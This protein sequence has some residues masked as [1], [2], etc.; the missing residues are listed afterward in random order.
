MGQFPDAPHLLGPGLTVLVST[1]ARAAQE[2]CSVGCAWGQILGSERSRELPEPPRSGD[3]ATATPGQIGKL[4]SLSRN[5]VWGLTA[6]PCPIT[7]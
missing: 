4:A 5:C 7:V 1:M 2:S 3:E 6:A